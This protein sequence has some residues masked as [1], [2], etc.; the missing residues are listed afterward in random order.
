MEPLL[1]EDP[2]LIG[3]LG[4]ALFAGE[5]YLGGGTKEE[6]KV[7]YG[8][9]DGTGEYFITIDVGRC[10]GCGHC[11]SA[12]P[13]ELFVVYQDEDGHPK[14]KVKKETRKNLALLCPGYDSCRAMHNVDCHITCP[15]NAISHT[16]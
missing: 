4:A 3:A 10:D 9:S 2:Q 6:S 8:Y 16:W 15:Q 13:A 5:R 14:V 1:C 7:N 11:V 12:C